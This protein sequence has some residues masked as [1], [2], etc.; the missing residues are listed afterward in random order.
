MLGGERLSRQASTVDLL[1]E[2]MSKSPVPDD[3]SELLVLYICCG[4]S[5]GCDIGCDLLSL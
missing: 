5:I 1:G 3:S 4:H 2:R